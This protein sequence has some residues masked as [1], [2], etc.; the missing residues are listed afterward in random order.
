MAFYF[1][2]IHSVDLWSFGL[3]VFDMLTGKHPYVPLEEDEDLLTSIR[4][5]PLNLDQLKVSKECTALLLVLL[6]QDPTK[7]TWKVLENNPWL[8]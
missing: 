4:N 8:Q 3:I 7:R 5:R 6:E 2:C 1:L